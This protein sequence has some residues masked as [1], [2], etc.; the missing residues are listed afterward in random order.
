[1]ADDLYDRWF[2]A[3]VQEVVGGG[4]D[5]AEAWIFSALAAGFSAGFSATQIWR[6]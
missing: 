6:E 4:G 3:Y 1:M 2:E 5:G